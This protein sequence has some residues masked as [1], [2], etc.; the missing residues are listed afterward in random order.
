MSES[1]RAF[2]IAREVETL[3]ESIASRLNNATPVIA[4]SYPSLGK[5]F[6]TSID[7]VNISVYIGT[8]NGNGPQ[9]LLLCSKHYIP[10]FHWAT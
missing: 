8:E 10:Q 6:V 4:V 2:E 9:Q 7:L 3:G 1:N 5:Y